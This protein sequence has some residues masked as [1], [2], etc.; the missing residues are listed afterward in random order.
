MG[1]IEHR[2][3]IIMGHCPHI[4]TTGIQVE[5]RFKNFKRDG[6]RYFTNE[7]RICLNIMIDTNSSMEG[8]VRNL[9]KWEI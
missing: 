4:P 1:E 7:G 8:R 6:G 2:V 9:Q 3:R 5:R